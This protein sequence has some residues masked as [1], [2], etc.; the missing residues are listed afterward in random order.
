[1]AV[2]FAPRI[3]VARAGRGRKRCK[4]SVSQSGTS[5]IACVAASSSVI[6]AE[7][8][9]LAL[10]WESVVAVSRHL[11]LPAPE[12][13]A[14]TSHQRVK[15]IIYPPHSKTRAKHARPRSW[16]RASCRQPVP[17]A[18]PSSSPRPSR[19]ALRRRP[20]PFPF[21]SRWPLRGHSQ[22]RACYS[23]HGTGRAGSRR[24]IRAQG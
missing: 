14:N 22:R 8:E 17:A 10:I 6:N 19:S 9:S 23:V 12:N 1:M 11:W 4:C 21:R 5:A 24:R 16:H 15:L 7:C 18:A 3:I 2:P 13:A 20:S